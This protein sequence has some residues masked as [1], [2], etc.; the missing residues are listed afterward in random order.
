MSRGIRTKTTSSKNWQKGRNFSSGTRP[1]RR[2]LTLNPSLELTPH[3]STCSPSMSAGLTQELMETGKS[4]MK[5]E[6]KFS[7][8]K[9]WKEHGRINLL[10]G[11]KDLKQDCLNG[12]EYGPAKRKETPILQRVRKMLQ[13]KNMM[14]RK[15]RRRRRR[16]RGK[17]VSQSR[18]E[19]DV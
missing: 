5:V 12:L 10:N 1:S 3:Q 13:K 8:L 9:L 7:G 11:R 17:W 14:K 19:A 18:L 4:S 2:G 6:L 15:K 16:K